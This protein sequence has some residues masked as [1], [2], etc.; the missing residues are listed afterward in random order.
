MTYIIEI[1]FHAKNAPIPKWSTKNTK[2]TNRLSRKT[3]AV[4]IEP[5]RHLLESKYKSPKSKNGIPLE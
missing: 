5:L 4:A 3:K 1:L 2:K